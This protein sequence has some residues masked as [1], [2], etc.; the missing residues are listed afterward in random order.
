M[1][2]ANCSVQIYFVLTAVINVYK[3][4]AIPLFFFD[5]LVILILSDGLNTS[6]HYDLLIVVN[7]L[8]YCLTYWA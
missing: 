4:S 5:F 6:I 8:L 3:T 1:V 2:S 7:P